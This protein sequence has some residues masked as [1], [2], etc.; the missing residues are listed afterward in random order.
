MSTIGTEGTE[1]SSEI[2]SGPVRESTTVPC[3]AISA[4]ELSA[5]ADTDIHFDRGKFS[6][7]VHSAALSGTREK[8]W[9]EPPR[10]RR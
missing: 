7:T 4:Q 9:V 1:S 6:K 2:I 8:F 10:A 3:A 5:A